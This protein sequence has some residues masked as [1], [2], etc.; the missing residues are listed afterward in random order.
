LSRGGGFKMKPGE[1][2]EIPVSNL[3]PNP[4]N[5]RRLFDDVPMRILQESIQQVGVLVPVTVYP[6]EEK[7]TVNVSRDIFVLLD[8]ERRWRCVKKLNRRTIPAIIVQ[9]PTE[10]NNI[11][12]MF[13]IHNVREPWMLMPT[14][15]KLHTLME[16]LKE[17]N[18]IKLAELTKLSLSQVRRCKI[19]LT[20]PK[21]HQNMLLAPPNERLK[22]DF[23]IELQRI[24]GPALS[25][26]LP[27]WIKRG[28]EKCIDMM[29]KKYLVT[30]A[31]T[32]VTQFRKLAEI[33]RGSIRTKQVKTFYREMGKFLDNPEMEI[34]DINVPGAGFEKDYKEIRR[35][36]K[37]LQSQLARLDTE[38]ISG[39]QI[40]I[41]V[42][43]SLADLIRNKLDEALVVKMGFAE[44][45][46]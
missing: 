2:K 1:V 39:D 21:K 5:P 16:L 30:H 7:E 4:H 15:L 38:A 6:K 19:L 22:A 23:F 40:M 18:E 37:R 13:A 46:S 26:K 9:K 45:K 12:Q 28:D 44:P 42:L 35:S 11:L 25:E 17:T 33:Y 34:E 27:F 14:A 24:R 43:S 10:A 8:G 20:Y 41:D 29:L 31:I 32:A 36:A 3:E